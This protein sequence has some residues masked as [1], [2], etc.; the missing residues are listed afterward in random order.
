VPEGQNPNDAIN[1]AINRNVGNPYSEKGL[2]APN[3]IFGA[4]YPELANGLY[5][6]MVVAKD[7][8]EKIFLQN[9]GKSEVCTFRVGAQGEMLAANSSIVKCKNAKFPADLIAVKQTDLTGKPSK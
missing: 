4:N 7:A 3:L 2:V 6:W 9:D 8:N 1:N 5:A